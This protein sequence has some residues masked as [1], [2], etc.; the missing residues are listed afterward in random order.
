MPYQSAA[1]GRAAS[2]RAVQESYDDSAASLLPDVNVGAPNSARGEGTTTAELVSKLRFF[3]CAACLFV[4]LFH[5]LPLLLNPVR[6]TLLVSSPVRL[7]LELLAAL[8]ALFLLVV[9]ARI[10]ILGEKA[11]LLMTK[12]FP[13]ACIDLNVARGRVVALSIMGACLVLINYLALTARGGAPS[14][15]P[16]G[17]SESGSGIDTAADE[18]VNAT[19][20]NVTDAGAGHDEHVGKDNETVF[21]SAF[22]LV[23]RC[24]IFS[25]SIWIIL[26]LVGYT[27]YVMQ[28][29]PEYGET[30]AYSIQGADI[31]AEAAGEGPSWASNVGNFAQGSG[32]QTVGS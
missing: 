25:P 24:I 23:I 21:A 26:L 2:G 22:F 30:R 31:I 9:E 14:S 10:P 3:N 15:S 7:V 17:E 12:L 28:T 4:L 5:S 32:Y 11:L 6:L 20:A 13:R 18:G 27:I 16:S 29:F 8:L 19:T 1:S